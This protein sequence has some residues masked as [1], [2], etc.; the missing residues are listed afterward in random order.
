MVVDAKVL[1]V[2]GK[3]TAGELRAVVGH[4][5]GELSADAGQPLGDVIDEGGSIPSRLVPG[6]QGP[7]GIA[8]GGIDGGEL[9][10]SGAVFCA[11]ERLLR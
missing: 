1:E 2:A 10:G 3:P 6:D 5:S 11:P 9:P 4:H 8:G 7:D